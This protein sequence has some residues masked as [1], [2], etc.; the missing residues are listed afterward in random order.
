MK[1]SCTR[2][3]QYGF[4]KWCDGDLRL[5]VLLGCRCELIVLQSVGVYGLWRVMT[6]DFSTCQADENPQLSVFV[7][8][9]VFVVTACG[10]RRT[11]ICINNGTLLRLWR[12]YWAFKHSFP[13][14]FVLHKDFIIHTQITLIQLSC[15]IRKKEKYALCNVLF[16]RKQENTHTEG[17]II[18]RPEYYKMWSS[19]KPSSNNR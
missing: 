1:F 19:F 15:I 6:S 16:G 14:W 5:D 9:G 10:C 13:F 12:I 4:G 3:K 8:A 17:E 2:D 11:D 18:A 7:K